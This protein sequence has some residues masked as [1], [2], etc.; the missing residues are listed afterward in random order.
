[1]MKWPFQTL[2]DFPIFPGLRPA[3]L[4]KRDSK[5]RVFFNIAKFLRTAFLTGYLRWLLL[6]LRNIIKQNHKTKNKSPI[7]KKLK[8]T[9][10]YENLWQHQNEVKDVE[11]NYFPHKF[12]NK[13]KF[14]ILLS[15]FYVFFGRIFSS[16]IE[17]MTTTYLL[18]EH[19]ELTLTI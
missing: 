18:H 16:Q 10:K 7:K 19:G 15:S 14:K 2:K 12:H 3:T 13:T 6:N 4:L 8:D 11:K 9:P 1:M 17:L 5:T